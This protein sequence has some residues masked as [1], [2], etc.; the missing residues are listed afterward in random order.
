MAHVCY[1]NVAE[2]ASSEEAAALLEMAEFV[3][4]GTPANPRIR[5]VANY[6]VGNYEATIADHDQSAAVFPRRAWDWLFLAMAQQKL[7]RVEEAKESLAK[8]IDWIERTNRNRASE[9]TNTW[10]SWFE[11]IEVEQILKE[12]N[13]LIH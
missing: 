9:S 7:G 3:V 5:G 10:I 1:I 8:A 6:R 2:P 12:A 11:S 4:A 13:G